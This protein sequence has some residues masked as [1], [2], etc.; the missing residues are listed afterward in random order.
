MGIYKKGSIY[1]ATSWAPSYEDVLKSRYV[2]KLDKA[3]YK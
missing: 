1:G 3:I 2:Y